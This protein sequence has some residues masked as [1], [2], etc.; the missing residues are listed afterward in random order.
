MIG[1][2][3]VEFEHSG[4]DRGEYGKSLTEELAKR[5]DTKGLSARNLW[6]FR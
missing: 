5:L 2:Y 3:L 6:L 1:F 4:K